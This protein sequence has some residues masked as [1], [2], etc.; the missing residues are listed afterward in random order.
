MK[1]KIDS[2]ARAFPTRAAEFI[3]ACLLAFNPFTDTPIEC[4]QGNTPA[5]CTAL[6]ANWQKG[7]D[8]GKPTSA[9]SYQAARTYA[10]SFGA[11]F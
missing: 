10:V 6:K 8:F 5:Q 3:I 1:T 4:P 2:H 7:P 9:N 11:R